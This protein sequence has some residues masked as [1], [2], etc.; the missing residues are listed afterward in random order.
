MILL[1][2]GRID[3][4]LRRMSYQILEE[5]QQHP[6][7]ILGLNR[8]GYSVAKRI[9]SI[10]EKASGMDVP[11]MNIQSDDESPFEFSEPSENEVLVL[12]DDVIFSGSSMFRAIQKIP[13][14][15]R[16]HKIIVA[17]LVDRGHRKFPILA[18]IVGLHVPTKLNEHVA[19]S[20]HEHSPAEV[21]LS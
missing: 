19:L 4:T 7:R 5:A 9:G 17:V 2:K 1:D 15:S 14:L 10:L 3:R 8:R 12:T 11:V 6:V 20:L 18:G 21:V 13:D 16:Y